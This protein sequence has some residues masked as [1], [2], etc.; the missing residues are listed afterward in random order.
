MIAFLLLLATISWHSAQTIRSVDFRNFAYDSGASIDKIVLRDGIYSKG[1]PPLQDKSRIVNL[2]Y[3]D[4]DRDG[5]Q[6]A[7]IVIETSV[8]G[9][10]LWCRDYYVF[11]YCNG[12]AQQIFHEW[13]ERGGRMRIRG[14][15]IE[16][17]APLWKA[18]AHC[19]PSF[20][21][22]V[23]YGWGNSAFMVASRR[24]IKLHYPD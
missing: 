13:R 4:F 10:M 3:V 24:R 16:I 23:S 1:T 19:C 20:S 15:S 5:K 17:T 18:D 2:R 6:E 7:A 8:I 9:S 12:A 22:T 21:E 14:R 11:A